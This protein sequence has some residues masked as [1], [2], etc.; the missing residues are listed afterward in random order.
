MAEKHN[1]LLLFVSYTDSFQFDMSLATPNHVITT[2]NAHANS[3]NDK[4]T[5]TATVTTTDVE[6]QTQ[7]LSLYPTPLPQHADPYE[8]FNPFASF[9]YLSQRMPIPPSNTYPLAPWP[10]NS[11][12]NVYKDPPYNNPVPGDLSDLSGLVNGLTEH[13]S[14]DPLENFN[15]HDSDEP[16]V[17]PLE[18][19]GSDITLEEKSPASVSSEYSLFPD[20]EPLCSPK[21]SHI[22][23]ASEKD[24]AMLG[25]VLQTDVERDQRSYAT[26][27][28]DHKEGQ[29]SL[30]NS[31]HNDHLS[32]PGARSRSSSTASNNNLSRSAS[33]NDYH[34]LSPARESPKSPTHRPYVGVDHIDPQQKSTLSKTVNTGSSNP[35][36]SY[37]YD[38]LPDSHE[39]QDAMR[40][41][42]PKAGWRPLAGKHEK[43]GRRLDFKP[44][45][46]DKEGRVRHGVRVRGALKS[47]ECWLHTNNKPPMDC[48]FAHSRIGDTLEFICIRCTCEKGRNYECRDKKA[49]AMFIC[50]L[51]PYRD[52]NGEK[53]RGRVHAEPA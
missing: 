16:E 22:N 42:P 33:S 26:A 21:T 51:G 24:D 14:Y 31:L 13:N 11:L 20:A 6:T 52:I 25:R 8:M 49:H 28:K 10:Y 23:A 53:W 2:S 35:S 44:Q 7:F 39:Y 36:F 34:P 47:M 19:N 27:L 38:N 5:Q 41:K 50:N 45:Y 48:L 12:P 3:A 9:H 43:S 4:H 30:P 1:S 15:P 17:I 46:I 32:S 37:F 18:K 40:E 29:H